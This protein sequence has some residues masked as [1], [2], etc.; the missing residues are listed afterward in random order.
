LVY[1]LL[2]GAR[3]II[4]SGDR[5]HDDCADLCNLDKQAQVSE[6][7]GGLSHQKYQWA[8]LLQHN[9]RRA[10]QEVVRIGCGNA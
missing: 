6:M 9:V 8:P 10:K 5:R 7:Q 3:L 2:D 1:D 4:E